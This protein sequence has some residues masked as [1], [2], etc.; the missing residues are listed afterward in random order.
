MHFKKSCLI[1]WINAA[2]TTKLLVPIAFSLLL[3]S[4]N[5]ASGPNHERDKEL[6]LQVKPVM[7]IENGSISKKD[8]GDMIDRST[9][10]RGGYV[11]IISTSL[12]AEDKKAI[13]LRNLFY[14]RQIEAVHIINV[15]AHAVIKNTH[16]LTIENATILCLLDG[17]SEKFVQMAAYPVL[18]SAILNAYKK[19]ALV[20]MNGHAC[21]L[22][23]DNYLNFNE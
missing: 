11:A 9:I 22:A 15:E 16:V 10:R 4:C 14:G 20:V 13:H 18:K 2:F 5:S 6:R 23:N 17:D 7:L 19:G 3:I 21:S 8:I 1:A 12:I